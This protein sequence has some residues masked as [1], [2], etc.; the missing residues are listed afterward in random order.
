V[1]RSSLTR[2]LADT[3]VFIARESGR[4]MKVEAL[5]NELSVSIITIG[6]L[7][8]GVLA[9]DDLDARERRLTTLTQALALEPLPVDDEVARTWAKL[10]VMLRDRGQRMALNDSWI[11]A[12]AWSRRLPVVTQDHD[13]VDIPG[14]EVIRV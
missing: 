11:A 8:A 4:P 7:R 14:L 2:G 13:Y 10:R 3:T 1:K 6:E 9:T 12:T 5:P